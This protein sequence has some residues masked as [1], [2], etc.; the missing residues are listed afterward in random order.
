VPSQFAGIRAGRRV[1]HPMFGI[2]RVISLS[3]G[4]AETRALVDFERCGQKKLI[5]QFARLEPLD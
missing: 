3:G 4:G 5:L 2:G 1:R